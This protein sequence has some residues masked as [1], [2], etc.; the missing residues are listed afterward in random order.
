MRERRADEPITVL[1]VDD[2]PLI[3]EGV[4]AVLQ[5][6]EDLE[7]VGEASDGLEAVEQFKTLKPDIVLMDLQMPKMG[8]V[9]AIEAIRKLTPTARII[10]LTTYNGDVQAL[11]AMKAGA[12]AYLL[13]SSL[14]KNLVDIIREVHAGRRRLTPEVAESIAIHAI[15]DDLSMREIEVLRLVAL[16][17]PNK[18]IARTLSLSEE[19]VKTHLKSIFSKLGVADRTHAV[20]VAL[21]R[22]FISL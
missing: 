20:T 9:D 22:G 13:K 6:R 18:Q 2:H 3:R 10:V 14:R 21:K 16:G 11:R 5:L 12:S 1:V 8:G 19:T 7:V 15:D 4:T 17:N